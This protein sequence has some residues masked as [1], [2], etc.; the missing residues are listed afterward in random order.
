MVDMVKVDDW[1][2]A[3]PSP[4]TRKSYRNGIKQFEKFLKADIETIMD[5]N[6]IEVGHILEKFFVSLKES[7]KTQNSCRSTFNGALQYMKYFGKNPRYRKA[8]GIFR[9]TMAKNEHKLTIGEVQEMGKVSDL[10]EQILLETLLLGLRISDASTL[11]WKQFEQ[12]EFVLNTKKE[13][14]SAHIFISE[15]FRGLLTK[16]LVLLDQKNPYLFQSVKNE[17]LTVKHLDYMLHQLA[18]RTGLPNVIHWHLGRKLVFRSGLEL[19]IPNPIMKLLLGKSVPMSDGT[20]YAEGINLKPDADKL[21]EVIRLFPKQTNGRVT[22]LEQVILD[23][24]KENSGLK[25]RLEILQSNFDGMTKMVEERLN[26]LEIRA[27]K[28]EKVQVT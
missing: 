4:L 3:I 15:E 1:L 13:N 22:K 5:K 27:K 20:Y 14:V 9:T 16:Y 11:E 6:D 17:H 24:E 25:T 28:K 19:G 2:S 18:K 10:R 21:H 7:G 8:L 12:D 26:W 23:L